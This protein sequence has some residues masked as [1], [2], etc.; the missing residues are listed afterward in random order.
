M[1]PRFFLAYLPRRRMAWLERTMMVKMEVIS[2]RVST[3]VLNR[4]EALAER[5]FQRLLGYLQ[6]DFLRDYWEDHDF[7]MDRKG[8]LRCFED[9]YGLG[10]GSLYGND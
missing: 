10:F 6:I 9:Y 7:V 3:P 5:E 8:R 2:V 1:M 4:D